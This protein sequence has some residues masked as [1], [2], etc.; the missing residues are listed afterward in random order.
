[1]SVV[2]VPDGDSV[3]VGETW[4]QPGRQ[5]RA[6]HA[7]PGPPVPVAWVTDHAQPQPGLH[8]ASLADAAGSTGLQPIL[9]AGLI[10]DTERPWDRG[11]F[12]APEDPAVVGSFDVEA[13]LRDG[14]P[15]GE[16]D[17]EDGAFAEEDPEWAADYRVQFTPYEDGFPGL[18]PPS[19]AAP[20]PRQLRLALGQ[21]MPPARIGLV[22]AARPADVLVRL[23]W[24]GAVNR[25]W[26]AA[27]SAVLRSWED[28]FGA[29]LLEVGFAEI[30]LLV[31][32]PPQTLEAA[33]PVAAEHRAFCDEC[34]R[35]GLTQV[36]EIAGLLVGNPFWDFW[37]D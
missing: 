22:P 29:R 5:V 4:L 35:M 27:L 36:S 9:L 31:S 7:L 34:G 19:I 28:R 26:S 1:M 2:P 12:A 24:Q 14:W 21:L 32:R 6:R 33:L 3:I 20:D 11:E 10:G 15:A 16:G 13:V 17:E 37:W 23:G 30:R 25:G 18:A 8:W